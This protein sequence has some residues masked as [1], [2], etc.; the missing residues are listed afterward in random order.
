MV[1]APTPDAEDLRDDLCEFTAS[2]LLP[3]SI[4]GSAPICGASP[5]LAAESA[6]GG[7]AAGRLG[8]AV[9]LSKPGGS[10]DCGDSCANAQAELSTKAALNN[11]LARLIRII[12][13]E[14]F[15][16]L[17]KPTSPFIG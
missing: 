9:G 10:K 13:R 1:S 6:G 4:T 11:N 14:H 2:P 8:R 3:P 17:A 16:R 15:P 12:T 7:A 5:E